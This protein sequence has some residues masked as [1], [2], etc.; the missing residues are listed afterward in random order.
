MWEI[1]HIS[2]RNP[3]I[4]CRNQQRETHVKWFLLR[5]ISKS[6]MRPQNMKR[7]YQS[8]LI[9]TDDTNLKYNLY[10]GR[11]CIPFLLAQVTY[12]QPASAISKL[13]S[14]NHI[15][16][17]VPSY[18]TS[19]CLWYH[20]LKFLVARRYSLCSWREAELIKRGFLADIWLE[21]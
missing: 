3:D 6:R 12:R 5:I 7:K 19:P 15:M 9:F 8:L 14:H 21:T 13:A 4:R 1:Y 16:N 20:D 2:L 18:E 11:R 10:V 17:S